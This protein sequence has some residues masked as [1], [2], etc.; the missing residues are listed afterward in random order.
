MS[1]LN[2]EELKKT[3]CSTL[4]ADV[5]VSERGSGLL[6]V[7]TPFSFPDGD[8]YSMYIKTLPTGGLRIS[9]MGETLMHLSYD[10]DIDKFRDGTRKKLFDQILS[11]M[12]LTEDN[13]EFFID[14]PADAIGYN[15]FRFGQALTRIHDL[16]FLNRIRAESTFYEDLREKLR[17]YTDAEKIHESYVVPGVANASNYPVDYYIE[18]GQQ[19]LYLF[20]VPSR[21][22]ARLA[23]IILQHLNAAKQDFNSMIIFQNAS[24]I[25]PQDT[26]RLMNAANDMIASLD[27][28][29]DFERKYLRKVN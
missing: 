8:S 9:D 13:G 24:D 26:A 15:L 23:T 25:P 2:I 12:D 22:K 1:N 6:Y 7:S 21:D 11:E 16:T 29:D 19:P 10:S 4:C 27:A 20:G 5:K 17:S 28:S 3:V 18:G 14:A